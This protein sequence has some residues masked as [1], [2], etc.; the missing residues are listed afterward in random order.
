MLPAF[1]QA[2][3]TQVKSHLRVRIKLRTCLIGGKK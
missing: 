2:P 1:P 3:L